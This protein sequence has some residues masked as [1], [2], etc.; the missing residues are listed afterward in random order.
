M[1]GN[2]KILTSGNVDSG[3]STLLG[4]LFYDLGKIHKDQIPKSFTN[5]QDYS[6]FFDGLEEEQL[7]K[8]TIDVSYKYLDLNKKRITFLDC[9]G[10]E[11]FTRNMFTGATQSDYAIMVIDIKEGLTEQTLK[12]LSIL[13]MLNIKKVLICIN[14]IDTI[15]TNNLK[16][17]YEKINITLSDSLNIDY[18]LIPTSATKGINV[19]SRESK[20]N[21][22][23]GKSLLEHINSLRSYKNEKD[24]LIIQESLMVDKKRIHFAE[25][26]ISNINTEIK[27][28]NNSND[29]TFTIKNFESS[30]KTNNQITFETSKDIVFSKGNVITK[31]NLKLDKAKQFTCILYNLSKDEINLSERYIL[32]S[33]H[34]ENFFE[35]TSINHFIS[36]YSKES[37]NKI[38]PNS[39]YSVDIDLD[40]YVNYKQFKTSKNLGSFSI[41][42]QETKKTLGA[43][44]IID[45]L[46]RSVIDNRINRPGI[47]NNDFAEYA[48]WIFGL[49]ASG[50]TTLAY[51]VSELL[52]KKS[53]KNIV[54]DADIVRAGLNKDLGFSVNDRNENIRRISEVSKLFLESGVVPIVTAITP[55]MSERLYIQNILSENKTKFIYMNTSLKTCMERDPKGLYKKAKS[56]DIKNMTGISMKF[57]EPNEKIDYIE[58]KNKS[59]QKSLNI[60]EK[61]LF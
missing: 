59:I 28:R 55:K 19:T 4:R 35:I 18:E 41:I 15:K 39:L 34:L 32:K 38:K 29:K 10:H 9:P 61:I 45:N 43:G 17:V 2:I 23:N 20:L 33:K 53:I 3:K 13:E 42:S 37:S 1:L 47:L 22:Y 30:N 16:K 7:Q 27:L 25:N 36:G 6:V 8:I 21:F 46:T 14:K 24:Y 48:L 12:H 31:D 60:V 49:S 50:K 58:I 26:Y 52:N 11:E 44:I 5:N 51:K 54:L 40:K 57:E 56:G